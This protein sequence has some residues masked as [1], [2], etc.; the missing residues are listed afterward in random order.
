MYNT[1][2]PVNS[3]PLNSTKP[4][5]SN[6]SFRTGFAF[7]YDNVPLNSTSQQTALLFLWS[8]GHVLFAGF[9]VPIINVIASNRENH[10]EVVE[11]HDPNGQAGDQTQ[12]LSVTRQTLYIQFHPSLCSM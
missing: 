11:V 3:T 4:V 1:V 12:H 8:Q 7:P 10:Y 2:K 5:N 9:T 6:M